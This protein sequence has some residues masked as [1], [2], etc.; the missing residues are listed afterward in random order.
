MNTIQLGTVRLAHV[1]RGHGESVV[2]VHGSNGDYRTWN[3]VFDALAQTFRAI[4]YSRRYHWPNERIPDGVDYSMQEHVEDLEALL[5]ALK[6]APAHLV[7]HS[8][9]GFVCLLLAARRPELVRSLVLVEP[10]VLT[11]F[12][13]SRPKP[14]EMV[15]LLFARPG[16]AIAIAR[17]GFTGVAPATA[18]LERGDL[19]GALERMG[20]A[21]L[22]REW[23]RNLSPERREQARANLI[24]AELLG[25]GFSPLAEEQVR[26]IAR[27]VL[28]L[29]GARSP[30]LFHYLIDRLAELIPNAERVEIPQ[31]SHLVHEQNPEAWKVTVLD[32]LNR[33]VHRC[34]L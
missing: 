2:L 14:S 25:S 21:V 32:F 33:N 10:P 27:P 8:Y 28:L 23:F 26:S 19:D 18:A 9:G 22:G 5:G 30:R 11:L 12:T 16:V 4:A 31:A 29:S 20:G 1:L 3:V 7:G 6:A 24:S 34:S 17:F 15:R 13:S